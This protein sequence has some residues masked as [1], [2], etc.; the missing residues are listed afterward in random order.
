MTTATP[1]RQTRH[2]ACAQE[3]R[4]WRS[5]HPPVTTIPVPKQHWAALAAVHRPL[6]DEAQ[7]FNIDVSHASLDDRPNNLAHQLP[8]QTSQCTTAPGAALLVV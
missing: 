1:S 4:T 2:V 8:V 6:Q 7:F 5:L 3:G